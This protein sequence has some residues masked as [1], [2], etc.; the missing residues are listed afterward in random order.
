MPL[1][2][3]IEDEP[4]I[5]DFL[6]RGLKAEGF[7]VIC[8]TEGVEGERHAMADGVDLVLLDRTLPGRDGLDLVKV[9]RRRRPALPVV[10]ISARAEAEDRVRA[11]DAGATDFMAK[12]FSFGELVARVRAQL[13]RAGWQVK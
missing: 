12:P 13:R 8:A 11:F 2:V 10:V 7:D 9:I 3:L 5:L 6:S 4:G 1:L